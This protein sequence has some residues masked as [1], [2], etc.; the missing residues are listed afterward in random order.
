MGEASHCRYGPL[1]LNDIMGNVG[2]SRLDLR[3]AQHHG[4][5]ED[6][7]EREPEQDR[8]RSPTDTHDEGVVKGEHELDDCHYGEDQTYPESN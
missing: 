4:S 8:T 1:P 3:A 2:R 5:S 6:Q 7:S